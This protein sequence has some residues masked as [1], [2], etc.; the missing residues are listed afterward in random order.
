MRRMVC[1]LGVSSILLVACN[2]PKSPPKE[3]QH[4][5]QIDEVP[6]SAE[7]AEPIGVMT[8]TNPTEHETTPMPNIPQSPK[9]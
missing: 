9:Q 6:M 8:P 1:L 4:I 5:K 3:T 2:Q 7:P